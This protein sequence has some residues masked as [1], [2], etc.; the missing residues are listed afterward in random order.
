MSRQALAFRS[1]ILWSLP[2]YSTTYPF[3]CGSFFNWAARLSRWAFSFFTG[4][5][6][7]LSNM[8]PDS[9]R[10]A[11]LVSAVRETSFET[12]RTTNKQKTAVISELVVSAIMMFPH[13]TDQCLSLD[14]LHFDLNNPPQ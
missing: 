6:P 10:V 12:G 8:R 11:S 5:T 14:G 13:D 4:R 9:N 3:E 7:Y 1:R 2:S